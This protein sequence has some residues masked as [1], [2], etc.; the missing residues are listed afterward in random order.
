MS[1][2]LSWVVNAG[3]LVLCCFLVANTANTVFASLLTP[4]P[5]PALPAA[6]G[7]APTKMSWEDRQVILDRNL[8]GSKLVATAM[9]E[10]D[11]LADLEETGLP[12]QLIGTLATLDPQDP[13]AVATILDQESNQN[14]SVRV[15]DSLRNGAASVQQIERRRI[16]LLERG[17]LR[18]LLLDGPDQIAAQRP[19]AK[20][21]T[22]R[23]HVTRPKPRRRVATRPAVPKPKQAVRRPAAIFS[24]AEMRPIYESGQVVGLEVSSIKP[25]SLFEE[26]G[27]NSGDLIT[28]FNGVSIDSPET[29]ARLL[30]EL[31][32]SD[33]WN[34]TYRDQDGN[35]R[36]VVIEAPN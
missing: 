35:E 19:K 34:I 5:D 2:T 25:G 24:Q 11:P 27:I 30:M 8:F 16:V 12:L 31:A 26:A 10:L 3:L 36:S 6:L 15:G 32:N 4:A 21:K 13:E 14:L 33:T 9:P 23:R 28:G 17:E 1:R 7:S 20:A 18:E 29:S 22:V